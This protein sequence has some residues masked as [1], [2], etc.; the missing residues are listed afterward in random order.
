MKGG[1]DVWYTELRERRKDI[2]SAITG[3]VSSLSANVLLVLCLY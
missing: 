2:M 1:V 3:N